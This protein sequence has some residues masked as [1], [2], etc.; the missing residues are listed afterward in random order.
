[1]DQYSGGRGRQ[2]QGQAFLMGLTPTDPI[3]GVGATRVFADIVH[4][5]SWMWGQPG[6]WVPGGASASADGR[7]VCAAA[8]W[9]H[10]GSPQTPRASPST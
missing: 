6:A 2:D 8:Q 7:T 9:E 5:L 10:I 1:M 4:G 3:D